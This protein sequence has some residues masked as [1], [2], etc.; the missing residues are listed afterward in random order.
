M[1][2][3]PVAFDDFGGVPVEIEFYLDTFSGASWEA[4]PLRYRSGWLMVSCASLETAVSSFSAPLVA[5]IDDDGEPV[6]QWLSSKLFDMRCSLPRE[7]CDPPPEELSALSEM[8]YWDFL[9]SCDLKHLAILEEGEQASEKEIARLEM[10]ARSVL[11]QADA[12]VSGLR[13]W[14]RRVDSGDP[15]RGDAERQIDLVE[16]KQ[17]SAAQWLRAR[18]ETIRS[19]L[20]QVETDIMD[21]IVEHGSVEHFYTVHW[22]VRYS[23]DRREDV[24]RIPAWRYEQN[25]TTGKG[26]PMASQRWSDYQRVHWRN[27]NAADSIGEKK[28]ATSVSTGAKPRSKPGASWFALG[29]ATI[30]GPGV[31]KANIARP[32]QSHEKPSHRLTKDERAARLA[33]QLAV[34]RSRRNAE[35]GPE[36]PE[37]GDLEVA[38]EILRERQELQKK[39]LARKLKFAAAAETSERVATATLGALTADSDDGFLA[40]EHADGSLSTTGGRPPPAAASRNTS[41]E[42]AEQLARWRAEDEEDRV[43]R[44]KEMQRD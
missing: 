38:A 8:L 11:A 25:I 26:H 28:P 17:L 1:R 16:Q 12:Y 18:I 36:A 39:R 4:S 40:Q 7:Q 42:R 44:G 35:S 32:A 24:S 33:A 5:C 27:G 3:R 30:S 43:R 10:R 9:G 22:V 21:A 29:P 15:R 6:S 19:H 14:L 41:D 31:G 2:S 34:I 13:A 23:R 20:Q 37:P